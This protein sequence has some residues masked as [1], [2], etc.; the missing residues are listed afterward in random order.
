M[1]F[2][3][4]Y[5]ILKYL[6]SNRNI[7]EKE[8][9]IKYKKNVLLNIFERL[10][11]EELMYYFLDSNIPQSAKKI[12][13][14]A[15]DKFRYIEKAKVTTINRYFKSRNV[16]DINLLFLDYY[17]KEFKKIIIERNFKDPAAEIING[18]D[19]ELKKVIIDTFLSGYELSNLLENSHLD[20]EIA[21]YIIDGLD[22]PEM[23]KLFLSSYGLKEDIKDRII[24]LKINKD[25]IKDILD[26]VILP[27][28]VRTRIC[29]LKEDC[30]NDYILSENMENLIKNTFSCFYSSEIAIRI[31]KLRKVEFENYA[32]NTKA[33]NFINML[34]WCKDQEIM[35]F[36]I[37]DCENKFWE[38][39]KKLTY[40]Q[41][42]GILS[43]EFIPLDIKGYI[44]KIKGKEIERAINDLTFSEIKLY[45]LRN[46]NFYPIEIQ[47]QIIDTHILKIT[48]FIMNLSEENIVQTLG[49]VSFCP[50]F[51][52]LIIKLRLN[53]EN[54]I[55]ILNVIKED[56]FPIIIEEKKEVF[57]LFFEKLSVKEILELSE[58]KNEKVRNLI[59]D[60]NYNLLVKRL[61]NLSMEEKYACLNNPKSNITIKKLLLNNL[62]VKED[63]IDNILELI[64]DNDSKSII[65]NYDKIEEIFKKANINTQ[66]FIQYGS[67]SIT[68]RNWLEELIKIIENNKEESFVIVLNYL[69]DNFYADEFNKENIAQEISNCLEII[70]NFMSLQKLLENIAFSNAFL[71]Q[72]DKENLKYLFKIDNPEKSKLDKLDQIDLFRE[73]L[74]KDFENIILSSNSIDELKKVFQELIFNNADITLKNIGGTEGLLALKLSDKN[75]PEICLFI[76]ELISY[77][78]TIELV[79]NSNDLESLRKISKYFIIDNKKN[80][81]YI[82]DA[83]SSFNKKVL[84]LYELDVKFNLTN[85]SKSKHIPGVLNKEYSKKLG[86]EVYDF[87]DKNYVLLAHVI[88][89]NENIKDII[90]GKATS[91]SN[92]ISTSAISYLGQKY[93]FDS[94]NMILAFDEVPTGNY[95]CSSIENMGT[96]KKVSTNSL[97]VEDIKRSQRGILE[98]S[99]VLRRNSEVLL[100]R[101]GLKPSGIVLP[102]GRMP[103]DE[104]NYLH[105]AYNLPFIL[106][107]NTKATIGNVKKVLP[108]NEVK[109]SKDKSIK[110]EKVVNLLNKCL[111]PSHKNKEYTGRVLALIADSHSMYEPTLAVLEDIRKKGI[112]EIY[113]LGD[114]IGLGPNPQE[115]LNILRDYN[116]FSIAGNSEYYT[117]LGTEPFSYFDVSKNE[118]QE[119]TYNKLNNDSINYL[120]KMPS[121]IDLKIG[122]K[123]VGLCHFANDVRWDYVKNSTWS[124]QNNFEKGVSSKQFLY[125]NSQEAKEEISKYAN[126]KDNK[127][128]G[129]LDALKN[130]IFNGKEVLNY[131]SI[132]EGH[133]HFEYDDFLEKTNIKTLR[134]LGIGATNKLEKNTA[135]YYILK[136]KN[137]GSFDIERVLVGF[138]RNNLLAKVVS[139]DIPNKGQ[140]LK[141][142]K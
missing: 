35:D 104:E 17:P 103:T 58:I 128:K 121:S 33:N 9:V 48:D 37:K 10:D 102:G 78:K 98:T 57:D 79:E 59:I 28:E 70:T 15:I 4:R 6:E 7:K 92:F 20:P 93:Y 126:I 123:L 72:K 89:K 55:P 5:N 140:V 125:T 22:S 111:I 23:I 1:I 77:A 41:V 69:I 133:V 88:N 82:Q 46:K 110:L 50:L 84:E 12:I 83:F 129:Y 94:S 115:V 109:I 65:D 118:N 40:Y 26:S 19:I 43:S 76:D 14:E 75:S 141:Y 91:K 24:V 101:E 71:T 54:I 66:M 80:L 21:N 73:K 25:N 36:L 61:K 47:Q 49:Y 95:I 100:Y 135:C 29:L 27:E 127:Y 38:S 53:D 32:R 106:T 138:N 42:L 117:T 139:S 62:N 13:A 131:D 45:H 67:G 97:D 85:L 119:W 142:L 8:K 136:E 134:A 108:T 132:F 130:P 31:L 107:Q 74:L 51:K 16:F 114:N 18:N 112:Q 44:I 63:N 11:A 120:K 30:I 116:V 3:N 39:M 124:Y 96:N 90:E 105:R 64:M 52:R 99:A 60:N 87:R 34:K 68:H 81:L 122:D 86:G 2:V 137:D 113:S 56:V